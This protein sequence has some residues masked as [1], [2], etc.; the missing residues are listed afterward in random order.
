MSGD[1]SVYSTLLKFNTDVMFDLAGKHGIRAASDYCRNAVLVK[2]AA[3]DEHL[4]NLI[5]RVV[6]R[7]YSARTESFLSLFRE[8]PECLL[9]DLI[10]YPA[11]G[12][13]KMRRLFSAK[14]GCDR[15]IAELVCHV[16]IRMAGIA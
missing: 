16:Q 5:V 1:D 10:D 6:Y 4:G 12:T 9:L 3:L 2:G 7:D 15:K 13:C 14:R 11:F 8:L